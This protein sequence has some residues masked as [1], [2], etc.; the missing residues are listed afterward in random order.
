MAKIEKTSIKYLILSIIAISIAG[1][2]LWPLLDL[3]F[4]AIFTHSEFVYSPMGHIVEPII[5]G[6]IAGIIFWIF[7]R[8]ASRKNQKKN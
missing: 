5:F 3:L 6:I 2:I 8:R 7:D 4:H 1:V